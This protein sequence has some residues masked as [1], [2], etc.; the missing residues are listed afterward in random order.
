LRGFTR[1]FSSD[2][3]VPNVEVWLSANAARSLKTSFVVRAWLDA[4]GQ[5][6]LIDRYVLAWIEAFGATEAAQFVYRAW[7]EAGGQRDLI[8][9]YVLA[10]IEAFG[11]T[12]A[13]RFVYRAWLE[14]GGQQ[15][16]IDRHV[17]AWIE[18]FG[19]TEAAQFV[20]KAWLEA[21]GQRDLI[22]R[23]VLTW[24][25]AFGATEAAQFVYKAWLDAGGQRDLID[26]HVLTWV[27]AHGTVETAKYVYDAWLAAGG[28]FAKISRSCLAWFSEHAATI[29]AGFVLKYIARQKA[30]PTNILHAAIRWCALFPKTDEAVW[31]AMSLLRTYRWSD[32][33]LAIVRAFLACLRFLNLNRLSR[34]PQG[35]DEDGSLLS[36]LVLNTLALSIGVLGLDAADRDELGI[37]H[38]KLLADSTIYEAAHTAGEANAHPELIH[39]VSGL[40][41]RGLIDLNRDRVGL[42]RFADWMRAWPEDA[43][44]DLELA[45]SR[46][47]RVA[48]SDLWDGIPP[49]R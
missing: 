11:A 33:A 26:N 29:E 43:Y 49:P 8:D 47:R 15:D 21:G 14:A 4:G 32:E 6:E 37:A 1:V 39:H 48:P 34:K 13:A 30:L 10:W 16:L 45:I 20:Y 38:A 9:R 40:I 42:V 36:H 17:L 12:E 25:E 28:D 46:L 27:E 18:A 23:H 24:I 41:E 5:R 44:E 19:A 22:E 35:V 31:R 3:I 2:E 7:L